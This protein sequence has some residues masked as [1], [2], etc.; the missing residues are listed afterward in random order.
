MCFNV[1]VA[2]DQIV[3]QA[4]WKAKKEQQRLGCWPRLPGEAF[5]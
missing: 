4:Y 3:E 2:F 5:Q 1:V